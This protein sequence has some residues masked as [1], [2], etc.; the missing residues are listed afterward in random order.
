VIGN[1]PV[2][3]PDKEQRTGEVCCMGWPLG[4]TRP[5]GATI[6]GDQP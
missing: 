4:L 6:K 2:M 5:P 1:H 3:L